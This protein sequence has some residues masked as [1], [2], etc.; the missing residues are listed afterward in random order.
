MSKPTKAEHITKKAAA[1]KAS[2]AESAV[3]QERARRTHA[4]HEESLR[5][6]GLMR[7]AAL[8]DAAELEAALQAAQQ[9]DDARE[10]ASHMADIQAREDEHTRFV[11]ESAAPKPSFLERFVAWWTK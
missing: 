9:A 4:A 10:F 3:A 11:E 7:E 1:L 8:R 6:E 2:L 5:Q